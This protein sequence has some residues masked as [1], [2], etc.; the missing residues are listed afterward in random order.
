MF[1]KDRPSKWL[2]YTENPHFVQDCGLHFRCDLHPIRQQSLSTANSTQS[3]VR[4][5]DFHDFEDLSALQ[6]AAIANPLPKLI[7]VDQTILHQVL[8]WLREIDDVCLSN[9]PH[10]MIDYRL[11]RLQKESKTRL[12]PL[13]GLIAR[14]QFEQSLFEVCLEATPNTRYQFCF[15]IWTISKVSMINLGI[16]LV[17]KQFVRW[18]TL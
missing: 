5:L 11:R 16:L 9:S 15:V 7:L 6:A 13:T 8:G 14:Q 2:N 12:D 10:E 18:R 3:E 4:L 17:I 1:L